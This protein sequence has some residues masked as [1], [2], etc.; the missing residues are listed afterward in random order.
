MKLNDM[1]EQSF[2]RRTLTEWQEAAEI[3]LK[4]KGIRSLHTKTYEN[5]ELKPLYTKEDL[6]GVDRVNAYI[7]NVQ[8]KLE[9]APKWFIAQPVKRGTWE[10]LTSAMKD[11]LS[12]GQNCVSFQVGDLDIREGFHQF[13]TEVVELETPVFS[14]E[15]K[16]ALS[17]Q[18]MMEIPELRD[19]KGV[20]G[21]DPINENRELF[22]DWLEVVK[23]VDEHLPNLKTIIIN[24]AQY[25]NSGGSATQEL[26]YG[27][28]EGVAY[29][30]TLQE[31]GWS[32]E[33]IA[34]KM[35]F[36][37]SV[38]SHFFMEIAKIRAFKKLWQEILSSYGLSEQAID[39]SVSC[40]AETSQLNKSTLDPY[41]NM[42]RGGGEAFSAI[43]AGVDYL[44]VAPFNEVSGE[45]NAFSERIARNTQLI[46]G[47][48]AHLDKVV[49]P[50]GGSYYVE[51]LS[52]E[53][54][55]LAWKEFQQV[56]GDG[57]IF[58]CLK[59]G[60][61]HEKINRVRESRIYDLATRKNS[62]IGTNIYS[63]LEE[64]YQTPS[65]NNVGERLSLP[66]ERLRERTHKLRS[67]PVAGLIGLGKL[68]THKPRADFVKGFLA[69]GGIHANQ[70]KEC[71]S[72]EDILQFVEET[73]YPYYCV[74]G[75]EEEYQD[76]L[77]MLIESIH[78]IDS[79]I[80]IDAAG[81]IPDE[82]EWV[83][84]GL[85]GSIYNKQNILKKVDELLTIWE[86]GTDNDKA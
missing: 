24:S 61:I 15:K 21:F 60:S 8:G 30:E 1:K 10:E 68:K 53:V 54:G 47:E 29:I 64:T 56:H 66:F 80:V 55:K 27:L 22:E 50:G 33:K 62:M 81:K 58:V 36:H 40:S 72:K 76:K 85:N 25:H 16:T 39:H 70:S 2:S 71:F 34:G 57:G 45:V 73:R 41:V 52:E 14:I 26:A 3:A 84:L 79:T 86:E 11:A 35:H 32:I 38:G 67:K 43:L 13:I 59:N 83:R 63:N 37:F 4:G 69:T 28:S 31:K 9:K 5:I 48:E 65:S 18:R 51:W 46:L 44:L 19:I 17:I 20:M 82:H 74:C 23:D 75:T 6:P 7:P 42:L 49:D 78:H 77:P 12:R